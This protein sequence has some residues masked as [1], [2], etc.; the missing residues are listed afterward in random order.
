MIS[1][2]K[3]KVKVLMVFK[4]PP[5]HSIEYGHENNNS[6]NNNSSSYINNNNKNRKYNKILYILSKWFSFHLLFFFTP[7]KKIP[8]LYICLYYISTLPH[9]ITR[10][11]TPVTSRNEFRTLNVLQSKALCSI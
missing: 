11:Y 1:S 6:N 3:S 7:N 5:L 2:R 4:L 8:H 9:S 10:L